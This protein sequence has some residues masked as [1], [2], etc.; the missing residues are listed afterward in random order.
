MYPPA[1]KAIAAQMVVIRVFTDRSPS[2]IGLQEQFLHGLPGNA[3]S[4][5]KAIHL[6]SNLEHH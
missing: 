2:E 6:A 5:Y 1:I 3:A 4:E